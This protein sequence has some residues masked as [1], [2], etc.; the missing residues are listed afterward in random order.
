MNVGNQ[1]GN[2]KSKWE[3]KCHMPL[4]AACEAVGPAGQLIAGWLPAQGFSAILAKRGDGKTVALLDQ[5]LSFA[6]NT[7]WKGNPTARGLFAVYLCGEDQAN[8]LDHA[9]AW[10][11]R[12][13]IARNDPEVRFMFVEDVPNLLKPAECTDLVNHL[14]QSLPANARTVIYLDTWQRA[15]DHIAQSDDLNA[16]VAIRNVE[17]IGRA[18]GGPVVL[19]CHPPKSNSKTIAGPMVV[20]N[21]SV[22]IWKMTPTKEGNTASRFGRVIEVERIKGAGLGNTCMTKIEPMEIGGFNNLGKP[23]TG[24]VLLKPGEKVATAVMNELRME[25][26]ARLKEAGKSVDE[27]AAELEIGVATVYRDLNKMANGGRIA[28]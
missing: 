26:V 9:K 10:Y 23:A 21:S 25:K 20:E 3:G 11:L 8:T 16:N 27:I 7:D 18:L 19:A 4:S 2:C 22:A 13:G 5:A 12:H 6:T 24:A 28:A 1:S 15:T 14:Q 17:M